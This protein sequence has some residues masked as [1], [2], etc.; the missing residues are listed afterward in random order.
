MSEFLIEVN[1]NGRFVVTVDAENKDEAESI[2]LD[3]AAE[4]A[5]A[6]GYSKIPEGYP[7]NV[8]FQFNY[9]WSEIGWIY[10]DGEQL[11][12]QEDEDE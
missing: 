2:A 9:D 3:K 1:I 5:Y 7:T 11:E 12:P 8:K 4:A 6:I 10:K